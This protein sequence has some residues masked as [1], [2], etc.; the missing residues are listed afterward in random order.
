[1]LEN[2]L[3]M[4]KNGFTLV[5]V[6]ITIAI[7]GIVAAMTL[8]G[9]IKK[10]QQHILKVQSKKVW[11]NLL[12]AMEL[13]HADNYVFPCHYNGGSNIC[14]N[15]YDDLTKKMKVVQYCPNKGYE[16]GCL[17]N[18]IYENVPKSWGCDRFDY[19][20][21]KV[22]PPV[23]VFM[24][25]SI[26]IP[27]YIGG[28]EKTMPLFLV[29]VNGKKG[30]NKPGYDLFNIYLSTPKGDIPTLNGVNGACLKTP[31]GGKNISQMIK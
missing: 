11:T 13:L 17:P 29:D 27:Y 18:Y 1:M 3:N 6:L 8:H 26:L 9:L 7:V 25:G 30:P 5:E 10:N 21:I 28:K 19:Q 14:Y 4:K 22:N 31:P 2:K 15:F 23:Y 16:R 12:S 20:V 24:D